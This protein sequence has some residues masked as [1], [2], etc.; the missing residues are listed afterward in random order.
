LDVS[1]IVL[2][3]GKGTRLGR[4][5]VI[6]KIGNQSLL[7]RVVSNLSTINKEIIVVTAQDSFLPQLTKYPYVKIVKDIYPGKGSLG[8]IYTGLVSSASL[9]NLV[10]ACDMPFLNL[11]LIKYMFSIENDFDVVIPKVVDDILEPLH[12]V[13]SKNCIDKIALLLIQNRLSILELFP[14]VRV[15]YVDISEIDLFDKKHLSFFNINTETD[16]KV[17]KDLLIKE[18]SDSDKC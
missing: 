14:M 11:D 2:A 13:Y 8:G 15:R 9:Y 5:K 3:G 16:L 12:A 4:N 18:D 1:C 17:G 10:V 7:E 6:E